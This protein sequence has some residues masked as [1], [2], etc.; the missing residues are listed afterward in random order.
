MEKA[1]SLNHHKFFKYMKPKFISAI[2]KMSVDS[3]NICNGDLAKLIEEYQGS[4]EIIANI[5]EQTDHFCT[6]SW[7]FK[8]DHLYRIVFEELIIT[9]P[10]L[11]RYLGCQHLARFAFSNLARNKD[12]NEFEDLKKCSYWCVC[13]KTVTFE[14]NEAEVLALYEG[15]RNLFL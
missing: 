14:N 4:E 12:V 11:K 15:F 5:I 3:C 1:E 9:E 13:N 8:C 7:E 6:K 2:E 10:G